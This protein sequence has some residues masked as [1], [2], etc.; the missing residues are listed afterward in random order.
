MTAMSD[1][2]TARARQMDLAY[3]DLVAQIAR[4]GEI[5]AA[6]ATKVA[7]AYCRHKCVQWDG[8]SYRA[9]TGRF[10]DP[11]VIGRALAHKG[12]TR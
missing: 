9:T 5:S 3:D 4:C 8:N 11:A 7:R 1:Y 12:E 6:D 10:F 2:L